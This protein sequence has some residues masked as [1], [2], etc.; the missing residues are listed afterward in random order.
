MGIVVND[1]CKSPTEV[2]GWG[3]RSWHAGIAR[4]RYTLVGRFRPTT[5]RTYVHL[6]VE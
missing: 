3:P 4:H 1:L 2:L 6:M 5:G